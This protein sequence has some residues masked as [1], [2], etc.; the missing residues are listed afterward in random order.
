MQT[1]TGTWV[2]GDD[3]KRGELG[4]SMEDAPLRMSRE[5]RL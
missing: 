5:E 3:V 4:R 2:H 1:S